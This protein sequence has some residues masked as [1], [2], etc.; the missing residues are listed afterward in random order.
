MFFHTYILTKRGPFAKIWLAAHWDRKLTKNDVRAI[1]LSTTVVNIIEPTVPIALRT[2]GELMLGVVRVY[3]H[4]VRVLLKEATDVAQ[5]LLNAKA[6]ALAKEGAGPLRTIEKEKAQAVTH[7]EAT[8]DLLLS[9]PGGGVFDAE[10][11]A[12]AGLVFGDLADKRGI[13]AARNDAMADDWFQPQTSQFQE[14]LR[15]LSQEEIF[16][17]QADFAPGKRGREES[18]PLSERSKKSSSAPSIEQLRKSAQG[19]GR[20][21]DLL[22][23]IGL[24]DAELPDLLPA[25]PK[26]PE[27]AGPAPVADEFDAVLPKAKRSKL[28]VVDANN[29]TVSIET[30]K[31]M[32][33]NRSEIIGPRRHGPRTELDAYRTQ[34]LEQSDAA[35]GATGMMGEEKGWPMMADMFAN[36]IRARRP[37]LQATVE[38]A[39]GS[40]GQPKTPQGVTAELEGVP[41]LPEG[42]V[43]ALPMDE[44]PPLAPHEEALEAEARK[45]KRL[46]DES[47]SSEAML[48]NLRSASNT[49]GVVVFRTMMKGKKRAEV[50]RS[51]A[52]V[53][54]LASL[55]KVTVRQDKPFGEMFVTTVA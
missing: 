45:S 2:S 55:G 36:A 39:R 3:G 47:V 43:P 23:D 33:E 34:Y 54:V 10:F 27:Q 8:K 53:L 6:E 22:M 9:A 40:T 31:H 1:D 51:F 7:A 35:S 15:A 5:E 41:T 14:G 11:D 12:I 21:A 46:R 38:G 44:L 17:L 28:N 49:K 42:E 20:E 13:P 37:W 30:F 26:T 32:M 29:T 52:D 25:P 16:A 48:A 19:P 18:V 50:A 4:K 24:P